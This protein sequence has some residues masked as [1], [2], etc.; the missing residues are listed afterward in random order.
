MVPV[1]WPSVL[2]GVPSAIWLTCERV[3]CGPVRSLPGYLGLAVRDQQG[4][5]NSHH[6][7]QD[8]SQRE[9]DRRAHH[10]RVAPATPLVRWTQIENRRRVSVRLGHIERVSPGLSASAFGVLPSDGPAGGASCNVMATCR[11]LVSMTAI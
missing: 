6:R 5:T 9:S 1:S 7:R 3:G 8:T 10:F 2:L 4:V 11:A